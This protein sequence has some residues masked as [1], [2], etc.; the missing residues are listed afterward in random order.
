MILNYDI[1]SCRF[2]LGGDHGRL[3]FIPPDDFSPLVE[4][5]LPQQILLIEPCFYFGNLDK[6]V[7][8]GPLFV[9]DD[10]A[11]FPVPVDTS[12]VNLRL[13]YLKKKKNAFYIIQRTDFVKKELVRTVLFNRVYFQTSGN[14]TELL[15]HRARTISRKYTR[16]VGIK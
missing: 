8:A 10:T 16:D 1:R 14:T 2:L 7:L 13:L 5:L 3:K 12:S 4:S 11:F 6:R 15:G 9:E